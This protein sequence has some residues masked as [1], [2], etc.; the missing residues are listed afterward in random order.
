MIRASARESRHPRA[1]IKQS[2]EARPYEPISLLVINQ[3]CNEL[4]LQQSTNHWQRHDV[5]SVGIPRQLGLD[6]SGASL[7]AQRAAWALL[8][9]ARHSAQHGHSAQRSSA[10]VSVSGQTPRHCPSKSPPATT[11]Q[12]Q[13]SLEQSRRADRGRPS[14]CSVEHARA[15]AYGKSHRLA[16]WSH[17][18]SQPDSPRAA[19]G[20]SVCCAASLGRSTRSTHAR[21]QSWTPSKHA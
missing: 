6:C 8:A 1:R 9:A 7:Q 4:Q 19:Q 5:C 11:L 3:S 15:R 2:W 12:S 20:C 13:K 14:Q 10:L 16:Q 18:P 21:A 17:R